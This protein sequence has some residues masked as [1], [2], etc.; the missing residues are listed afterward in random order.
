[1][2]RRDFPRANSIHIHLHAVLRTLLRVHFSHRIVF[3]LELDLLDAFF[4]LLHGRVG[5][6]RDEL[7][8]LLAGVVVLVPSVK[9]NREGAASFPF[10][11]TLRCAVIPHGCCTA[12][13]SDGD[14]L[15]IEL[16]LWRCALA[17]IDF[18]DIGVCYHLIGESTY[19]PFAVFTL[20][21][22]EL[23]RAHVFDKRAS[24]DWDAFGLDPFLVWA[25]FVQ[26][27][28]N[29]GMNFKFFGWLG[30]HGD[31]PL[32]CYSCRQIIAAKNSCQ[33]Y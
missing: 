25:I 30:S 20:P 3:V 15:F 6:Q 18:S 24:D 23:F 28:L 26:H 14:N 16:P 17:R 31:P 11:D 5:V 19:R 2:R 10:K 12:T 7:T 21:I 33:S 32:P 9:W 27:K 13:S 22:V 8:G 4:L 29:I 1:M